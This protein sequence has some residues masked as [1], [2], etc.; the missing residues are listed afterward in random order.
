MS[1]NRQFFAL[2]LMIAALVCQHP[3]RADEPLKGGVDEEAPLEPSKVAPPKPLE[4]MLAPVVPK[5]P[6][7]GT[8][9]K[10]D[11]GK[12]LQ[13]TADDDDDNLS[14]MQGKTDAKKPLQGTAAVDDDPLSKEDPDAEDQELQVAWD[15][16]RNK[17]LWSVQSSVQESLNNPDD[18]MLRWDPQKNV[19]MSRF[20]L[21]T[22][23]WFT[24]QVTPDRHVSN[25]KLLRTS[26]FPNFDKAVQDAVYSLEGS[27]I[28]KYPSRSRRKI[29]TQ[30]AGIKTSDSGER[31]FFHFGDV[32]HYNVPAQ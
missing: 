12:S 1:R 6:L 5:K 23:A 9:D 11:K 13:G 20:P 30:I 32:E 15:K 26:G 8:V 21:G 22:V 18:S 3:V 10:T 2:A 16:W 17:F 25:F 28:L 19:V 14:A 31:Q 24:C 27:T 4:P 29:V 7:Q